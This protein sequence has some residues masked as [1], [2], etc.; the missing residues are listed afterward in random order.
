MKLPKLSSI[1]GA[2]TT[3]TAIGALLLVIVPTPFANGVY[4]AEDAQE[5]VE[6]RRLFQWGRD[7]RHAWCRGTE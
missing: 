7:G 4:D 6:S 2:M 3:A 1:P 5:E